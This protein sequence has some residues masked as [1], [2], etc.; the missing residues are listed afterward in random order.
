MLRRMLRM[1]SLED[2]RLTA[3]TTVFNAGTG[4]LR[5][6]GNAADDY[7]NIEGTGD[8]G[9]M[10]VF[11]HGVQ[12]GNV[13]R[14]VRSID[15]NLA[16]GNDRLGVTAVQIGGSLTVNMGIGND[17]FGMGT[18][19]FYSS[20]PDGPVIIGGSVQATMGNNPIDWVVW[21]SESIGI[22]V[23]G[24]VNITQVTDVSFY[25]SG[26]TLLTELSDIHIGGN[27]VLSVSAYGE[28]TGDGNKVRLS[29]VNVCGTTTIQGSSAPDRVQIT[30]SA[31]VRRVNIQLG[32]GNDWLG[33]DGGFFERNAFGHHVNFQGGGGDDTIDEYS[34]NIFAIP[35]DVLSFEQ[36]I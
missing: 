13:L 4:L 15:A 33:L 3:V 34:L 22:F 28:V 29:N 2:R 31:F 7:V 26:T 12:Q 17:I 35:P 20:A 24:N 19:P 21:N 10:F 11:V 8:V 36:R 23:G 1:E 25:G 27:L 32:A 16:G 9:S 18:T 6:T 30:D 5:L 14:G